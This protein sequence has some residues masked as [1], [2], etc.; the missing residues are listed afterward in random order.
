MRKN[1]LFALVG[2]LVIIILSLSGCSAVMESVENEQVRE[3][4]EQMLDAIIDKDF[5]TA[6]SFVADAYTKDE[7]AQEYNLM[8]PLLYDVKNYELKFIGFKS[9]VNIN[10]GKKLSTTNSTY[11]MTEGSN[12]Y[13][14]YVTTNSD[15]E[16]L[17]YF[18]VKSYKSTNLY[19]TGTIDKMAD[20]SALQWI[21]IL[22][23]LVTIPITIIA[24]IDCSKQKINKKALWLLI[25]IFGLLTI[26][27]SVSSN[28]IQTI[29]NLGWFMNY[30]AFIKYGDGSFVI[31]MM[32][33]VGAIIYFIFRKHLINKASTPPQ[34][35]QQTPPPVSYQPPQYY[36]HNPVKPPQQYENSNSQ[37]YN[38]NNQ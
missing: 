6:Y 31:R 22:L 26:G 5:E 25:I 37:P 4:T 3:Y 23:N 21:M 13:V 33:P 8:E 12:R 14:V 11:E 30:S 27:L 9:N 10:N 2:I 28:K 15:C 1:R 7:F 29:T 35:P 18:N 16:K 24:V 19:H 36:P 32:I 38:D 17:S 20:A 34:S